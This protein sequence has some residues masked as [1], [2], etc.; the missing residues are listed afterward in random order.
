MD[1][2]PQISSQ[3]SY[4]K[5]QP[6]NSLVIVSTDVFVLISVIIVISLKMLIKQFRVYSSVIGKIVL[7]SNIQ[8]FFQSVHLSSTTECFSYVTVVEKF[9]RL[10]KN[11]NR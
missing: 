1:H 5:T 6:C 4:L 11:N 3:S 8:E 10:L 9:F 2:N 7:R